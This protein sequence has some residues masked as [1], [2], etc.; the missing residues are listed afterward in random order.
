M[1]VVTAGWEFFVTI[2]NNHSS[3]M[4]HLLTTNIKKLSLLKVESTAINV[5]NVA[6]YLFTRFECCM[7]LTKSTL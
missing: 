4:K 3:L 5:R 7:L 1:I 6:G 2:Q